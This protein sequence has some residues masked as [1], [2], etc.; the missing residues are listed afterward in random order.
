MFVIGDAFFEIEHH[1]GRDVGI[2]TLLST[3]L[4]VV[5]PSV[6]LTSITNAAG[7]FL[8]AVIPIPAIRNF[9][10]QVSQTSCILIYFCIM[11]CGHNIHIDTIT[12]KCFYEYYITVY[13]RIT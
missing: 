13:L 12:I 4:R 9:A 7:F 10:I 8:S 11:H 3:T 1:M 2:K 5:G 6:T